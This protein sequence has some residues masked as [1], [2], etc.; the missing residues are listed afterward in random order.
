VKNPVAVDPD[1]TLRTHAEEH[2]WRVITL[3]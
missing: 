1:D 3:R 2:G